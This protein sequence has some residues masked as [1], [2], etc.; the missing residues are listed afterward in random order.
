MDRVGLA[1]DQAVAVE[2]EAAAVEVEAAVV[3]VVV[4]VVYLGIFQEGAA[5][6]FLGILQEAVAE[7]VPVVEV[8]YLQWVV[9]AV[10]EGVAC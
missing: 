2:V 10:V 3:E 5:V 9:S 7:V 4:P 1:V 8:V 6:A